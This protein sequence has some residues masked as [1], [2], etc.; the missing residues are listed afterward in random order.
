MT[1][2]YSLGH[3]IVGCGIAALFLALTLGHWPRVR[4]FMERPIWTKL[5]RINFFVYLF[6]VEIIVWANTAQNRLPETGSFEQFRFLFFLGPI[7]YAL[8]WLVTLLIANPLAKL[9]LEFVGVYMRVDRPKEVAPTKRDL[10][11]VEREKQQDLAE[12]RAPLTTTQQQQPNGRAVEVLKEPK[13]S[14]SCRPIKLHSS[15]S[16]VAAAAAPAR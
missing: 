3:S 1:V 6:Q 7:L 13:S 9:E 8:A 11:R 12:L 16:S 14:S 15:S 4:Q 2:V 10:L 5:A